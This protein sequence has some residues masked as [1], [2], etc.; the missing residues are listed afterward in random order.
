MRQPILL[1]ALALIAFAA[2]SLLNR[3]ALLDGIT[4]PTSFAF[5][6]LASGVVFLLLLLW[7]QTKTVQIKF[8][9][10]PAAAL[11]LYVIGFSLSYVSLATGIGALILFGGVQMTLFGMA[12]WDRQTISPGR[13]A[14]AMISFVGLVYLLWPDGDFDVSLSG[15]VLM[16]GAAIGWGVYTWYGRGSQN[17][18]QDTASNFVCATPIAL[19]IYLFLPDSITSTAFALA[20]LSGAM[21]SGAGYTI[22]YH[23]LPHLRATRA[24]VLQ[25]TVPVI[26]ALMGA[27]VLAEPLTLKFV[28]SAAMVILGTGLAIRSA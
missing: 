8:R 28:I 20:C 6:R 2:N 27:V 7:W 3:W 5:V 17:P 16:G 13:Y 24:A 21:T 12:L 1:T 14:G 18:I 25:L 10:K 26:A 15:A 22:W 23:V 11:A 4:G 19:I 9:P